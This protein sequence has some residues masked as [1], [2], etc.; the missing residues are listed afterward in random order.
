MM[1]THFVNLNEDPMLSGVIKHKIEKD[2]PTRIGRKD[3]SVEPNVVLTGLRY[4]CFLGEQFR[5]AYQCLLQQLLFFV[6]SCTKYR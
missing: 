3:A 6:A 1:E 4:L 5:S 2:K